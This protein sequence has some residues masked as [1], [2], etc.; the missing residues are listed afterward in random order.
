M[1]DDGEVWTGDRCIAPDDPANWGPEWE[2]ISP[3]FLSNQGTSPR[4]SRDYVP[5]GFCS[6]KMALQIVGTSRPEILYRIAR[7]KKIGYRTE[8]KLHFWNPTELEAAAANYCINGKTTLEAF[9][10]AEHLGITCAQLKQL[11]WEK[12]KK[13]RRYYSV[14]EVRGFY[15]QIQ[16]S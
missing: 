1:S 7:Q 2:R 15:D 16:N 12:F 5:D 10:A 13:Y 9:E 4:K 6:Q 8:G 11:S 3:M 14:D